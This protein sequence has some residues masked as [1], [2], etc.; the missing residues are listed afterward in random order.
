MK[1]KKCPTNV[2]NIIC[3]KNVTVGL[4]LFIVIFSFL[5]LI[6]KTS[7][8]TNNYHYSS[9][10][11]VFNKR[12]RERE[13]ERD[14]NRE[15]ERERETERERPIIIERNEPPMVQIRPNYGYTNLPGDVLMNPYMP[16]VRDERYLVAP[17]IVQY[18]P[19]LMPIN[20]PTNRGA[21]DTPFRQVGIMTPMHGSSKDNI[22]PLIGRPVLVSRDK[23]QYYTMSNQNNSIK[24][25]LVVKGRSA[26]DEYGVDKLYDK[27]HVLVLGQNEKYVVTIYDNDTI[28]YIPY[29]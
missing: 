9:N 7:A 26:T 1:M 13:S 11:E 14:R 6:S 21:V 18:Q 19:G 24:L 12:E 3:F 20:V 22:L 28:R 2:P 8:Q 10:P 23:W 27:D 5:Y 29:I 25:P 17:P 16:P 4:L 15:R